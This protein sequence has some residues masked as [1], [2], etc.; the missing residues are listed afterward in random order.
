VKENK[1]KDA[2]GIVTKGGIFQTHKRKKSPVKKKSRKKKKGHSHETKKT[3]RKQQKEQG[4]EMFPNGEKKQTRMKK[5]TPQPINPPKTTGKKKERLAK[6]KGH[7]EC[8]M[9]ESYYISSPRGNTKSAYKKCSKYDHSHVRPKK[10]GGGSKWE[11][12]GARLCGEI[13]RKGVR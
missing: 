11:E 10:G 8:R 9:W 12:G 3:H 7:Q 6:E 4:G 5:K 1:A 13:W 2:E